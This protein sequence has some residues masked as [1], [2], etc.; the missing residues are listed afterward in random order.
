MRLVQ[1]DTDF[2][3]IPLPK[4][5]A[6]PRLDAALIAMIEMIHRRRLFDG[7]AHQRRIRRPQDRAPQLIR[8]LV[9]QTRHIGRPPRRLGPK[10]RPHRKA[11]LI[12]KEPQAHRL[13]QRQRAQRQQNDLPAQT[14]EH[15]PRHGSGSTSAARQ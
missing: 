8:C 13:R 2:P 3:R 1:L 5:M 11:P 4:D 6:H 10:R 15:P 14:V 12:D 9:Q 7:K